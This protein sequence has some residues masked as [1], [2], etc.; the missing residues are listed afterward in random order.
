MNNHFNKNECDW[1]AAEI[2]TKHKICVDPPVFPPQEQFLG[3]AGCWWRWCNSKLYCCSHCY[4]PAATRAQRDLN[5][6]HT[7][8]SRKRKRTV[9]GRGKRRV[10][11][12]SQSTCRGTGKGGNYASRQQRQSSAREKKHFSHCAIQLPFLDLPW[13]FQ[14]YLLYT[15]DKVTKGKKEWGYDILC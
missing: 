3:P 10:D 4:C 5:Q 1:G 8:E 11:D 15:A 12:Y 13:I 2:K 7:R 6:S 9:R 14:H